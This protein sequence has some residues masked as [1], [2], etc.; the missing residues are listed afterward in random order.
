MPLKATKHL[1][2][3]KVFILLLLI[4]FSAN[5]QRHYDL[6]NKREL[7]EIEGTNYQNNHKKLQLLGFHY[8]QTFK[9]SKDLKKK[10]ECLSKAMNYLKKANDIYEKLKNNEKD[11]SKPKILYYYGLVN[12]QMKKHDLAFKYMNESAMGKY[13]SAIFC[14]AEFYEK[15]IGTPIDIEKAIL[16]YK[17]VASEIDND[18]EAKASDRVG[19]L[20]HHKLNDNERAITWLGKALNLGHTESTYLFLHIRDKYNLDFPIKT[21]YIPCNNIKNTKAFLILDERKVSKDA[22]QYLK[23]MIINDS[24]FIE[25]AKKL[26]T[27]YLEDY[28]ENVKAVISII[29]DKQGLYKETDIQYKQG[30]N[31]A[32]INLDQYTGTDKQSSEKGD[33]HYSI[34]QLIEEKIT[35]I[36]PTKKCEP[37]EFAVY[38]D[39]L[40]PVK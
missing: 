40:L 30:D 8:Y 15:G 3:K 12:L 23:S 13:T 17:K 18:L 27:S 9:T 39:Y 10:K 35:I 24:N 2:M 26:N 33:F 1:I 7:K 5:A 11:N 28:A 34:K 25:Q 14:L 21:K 38:F 37:Q 16:N 36:S 6:L 20:Y 22:S 32:S 29:F 19:R 4:S 31:F